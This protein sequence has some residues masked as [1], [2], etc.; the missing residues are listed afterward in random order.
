MMIKELLDQ[1]E[2]LYNQASFIEN[3]PISIPHRYSRKQ[4]IEIAGLMAAVFAWGQRKTIINSSRKFLSLMGED[5]YDFIVNHREQHRLAFGNFKHRTFQPLDAFA[6]LEFLQKHYRKNTSLESAFF[7]NNTLDNPSV[8]QGISNFHNYFFE[9]SSA[10]N[11]TR[12][13]IGTPERKSSCKRLNMYLRWMVRRDNRGVDFGIWRAIHPRDLFMPLDVHVERIARELG[14]L[15][16]KQKDWKSVEELTM[17]MRSF[18]PEDPVKYD[19]ALFGMSIE[20]KI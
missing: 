16:R 7:N 2:E 5:P 17:N 4:N 6:F 13:H 1:Y 20:R 15:K 10:L 14:L 12:K 9:M 3:D 19:F 11:R 8:E 18:D